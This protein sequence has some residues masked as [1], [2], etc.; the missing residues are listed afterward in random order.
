MSPNDF[1]IYRIYATH[2]PYPTL[3]PRCG[4]IMKN[5]DIVLWHLYHTFSAI[6]KH[7][8]NSQK[9][10][11]ESVAG[12]PSIL[13]TFQICITKG[14]RICMAAGASIICVM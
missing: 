8:P 5:K 1:L 13:F 3:L 7:W 9:T 2:S 4:E 14:S 12:F 11:L 6:Q 10:L